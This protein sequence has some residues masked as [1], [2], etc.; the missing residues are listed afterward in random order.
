MMIV[1]LGFSVPKIKHGFLY[2]QHKEY[3]LVSIHCGFFRITVLKPATEKLFTS[4]LHGVLEN[5]EWMIENAF[6]VRKAAKDTKRQVKARFAKAH[7]EVVEYYVEK[8]AEARKERDCLEQEL[9][10]LKKAMTIIKPE[11]EVVC[12]DS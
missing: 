12:D 11:I 3:P 5:P 9:F 1:Q 8:F 2:G 7:G 10:I 4:A 6:K